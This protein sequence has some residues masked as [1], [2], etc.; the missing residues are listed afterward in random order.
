MKWIT[1]DNLIAAAPDAVD[2]SS[3][4]KLKGSL[5]RALYRAETCSLGKMVDNLVF[6]GQDIDDLVDATADTFHKGKI[7][8][9]QYDQFI[10]KIEQF[11]W[12]TVPWAIKNTLVEKCGCSDS[13]RAGYLKYLKEE[14]RRA[15]EFRKRT[16]KP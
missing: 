10:E 5:E 4:R 2:Q 14:E 15:G 3:L 6:V 16:A 9:D 1:I 7:E 8:S 11:Q 13:P 12:G